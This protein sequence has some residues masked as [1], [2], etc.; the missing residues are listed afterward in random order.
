MTTISILRKKL[1]YIAYCK[2]ILRLKNKK[3]IKKKENKQ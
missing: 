1:L 2:P 3:Y